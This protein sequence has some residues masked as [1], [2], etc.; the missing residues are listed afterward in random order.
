MKY[1]GPGA[2]C[3]P[4]DCFVSI[5]LEFRPNMKLQT[6]WFSRGEVDGVPRVSDLTIDDD[7]RPQAVLL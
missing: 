6:A 3:S 5:E 1:N 7:E 4:R 2:L